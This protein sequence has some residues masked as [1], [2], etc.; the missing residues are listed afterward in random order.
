[1]VDA[2]VYSFDTDHPTVA[3]NPS[4]IISGATTFD[5]K[6]L[7]PIDSPSSVVGAMGPNWRLYQGVGGKPGT[8]VPLDAT[9]KDA[10]GTSPGYEVYVN[11]NGTDGTASA[12]P[13][14]AQNKADWSRT[15]YGAALGTPTPANDPNGCG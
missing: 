3:S 1:N 8:G 11:N 2:Q 15:G 9:K 5:A 6:K 7:I 10:T 4:G 14:Q 13:A 12:N